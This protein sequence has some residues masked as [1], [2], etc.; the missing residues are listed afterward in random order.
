MKI[1]GKKRTEGVTAHD[2]VGS[3]C[4][5]EFVSAVPDGYVRKQVS[6]IL[7]DTMDKSTTSRTTNNF[8]YDD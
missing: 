6:H 5:T 3:R 4:N 8:A 2:F 7:E 1:K